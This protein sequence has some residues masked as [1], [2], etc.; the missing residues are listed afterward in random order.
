M[1]RVSDTRIPAAVSLPI[2]GG[3]DVPTQFYRQIDHA[4]YSK[5]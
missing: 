2:A 3:P 4:I 5:V 1:S